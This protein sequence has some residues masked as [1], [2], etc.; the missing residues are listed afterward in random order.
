MVTLQSCF[1]RHYGGVVSTKILPY[2]VIKELL[3]TT[4]F[5]VLDTLYLLD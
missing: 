3:F 5:D 2:H 4:M 1:S